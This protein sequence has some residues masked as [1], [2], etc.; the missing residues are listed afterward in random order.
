MS[1]RITVTTSI[2]ETAQ[3]YAST[4]LPRNSA[5]LSM[6][7]SSGPAARRVPTGRLLSG[8]VAQA[9]IARY[10]MALP[11]PYRQ[12]AVLAQRIVGRRR[13][14][15][16]DS[17]FFALRHLAAR[18]A[19]PTRRERTAGGFRLA[20]VCR[21]WVTFEQMAL[22]LLLICAPLAFM[23]AMNRS[24][25][26]LLAWGVPVGLGVFWYM[27]WRREATWTGGG[28]P[29]PGLVALVGKVSVGIVLVAL[30]AGLYVRYRDD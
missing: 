9:R 7:G 21:P 25:P 24:V 3:A 2:R 23:L 6:R 28:D 17:V 11:R 8:D 15:Y 29:Q 13:R 12:L 10:G 1:L 27:N 19:D 22:V 16:R 26:A 30:L 20:T 18:G 5:P 4:E 14:V